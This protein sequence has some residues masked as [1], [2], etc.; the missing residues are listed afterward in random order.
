MF[1]KQVGIKVVKLYVLV[2]L[3]VSIFSYENE[4]I[5]FIIANIIEQHDS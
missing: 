5:S 4:L 2:S 1:R 3:C